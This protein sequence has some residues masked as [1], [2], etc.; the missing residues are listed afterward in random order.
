[1][2]KQQRKITN[3]QR[4]IQNNAINY[5]KEILLSHVIQTINHHYL[6]MLFILIMQMILLLQIILLQIILPRLESSKKRA[7]RNLN[8]FET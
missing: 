5:V 3:H 1:M 2:R 8:C 4:E 7:F 6:L